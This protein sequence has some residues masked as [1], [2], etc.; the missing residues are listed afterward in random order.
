MVGVIDM[1]INSENISKVY[2]LLEDDE[3]RAIFWDCF[4][5]SITNDRRYAIDKNRGKE[6]TFDE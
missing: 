5:Y 2:N 4:K 3:S 6:R 1:K